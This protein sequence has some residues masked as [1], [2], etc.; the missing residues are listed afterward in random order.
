MFCSKMQK[1]RGSRVR[2]DHQRD[3]ENVTSNT[4]IQRPTQKCDSGEPILRSKR[5][6][7]D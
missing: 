7:I 2:R 4:V 1:E 3:F 6:M 5:H